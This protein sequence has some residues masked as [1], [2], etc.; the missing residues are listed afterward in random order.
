MTRDKDS[1]LVGKDLREEDLRFKDLSDKILFQT[2]L[3]SARMY[4]AKISLQCETFDSVQLDNEQ[5]ASLLFMISQADIDH[6]WTVGLEKLIYDVA[7]EKTAKALQRFLR[8]A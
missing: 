6:Q 1:S 3:R 2:D 8:L 7:G 4:G 5:V